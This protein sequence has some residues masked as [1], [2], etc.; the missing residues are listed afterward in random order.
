[1]GNYDALGFIKT[2]KTTTANTS[3][4]EGK[5][6]KRINEVIHQT[7]LDEFPQFYHNMDTSTIIKQGK[8]GKVENMMDDN[9]YRLLIPIDD[10]VT[11][12]NGKNKLVLANAVR[13]SDPQIYLKG[14][15]NWI[16]EYVKLS[17]KT[18]TWNNEEEKFMEHKTK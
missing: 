18:H 16:C 15:K 3:T 17:G 8:D 13:V 4:T 12:T 14:I 7:L 5:I 10:T 1:M 11:L 9:G 6:K 2:K